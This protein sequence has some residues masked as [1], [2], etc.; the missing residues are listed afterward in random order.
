MKFHTRLTD[1]LVILLLVSLVIG[2]LLLTPPPPLASA[3]V[4]SPTATPPESPAPVDTPPVNMT[5]VPSPSL[6]PTETPTSTPLPPADTS[7]PLPAPTETLTPEPVSTNTSTPTSTSTVLPTG[8]ATATVTLETTTLTTTLEAATVAPTETATLTATPTPDLSSL[9]SSSITALAMPE[10]VVINEVAWSGTAASANHEWLELYN[11]TALTVALTGWVITNT[12][13]I[14]IPLSGTIDPH[15][16]YLIER[17]DD[18]ITDVIADITADLTA[19]FVLPNAGSGVNLFLSVGGV[20][21]DTANANADAWPAGMATPRVS[22]ER[23]DPLSPD[24]ASNWANN[25]SSLAWNGHAVNGTPINGTPKQPNSTTYTLPPVFP[26]LIGE[27]LYDGLT[28]STEGDEFVELCNPVTT[29]VSLA[30]YKI[31]DEETRGGGESM[32]QLPNTATIEANSCRVVAKN[33][34]QFQARFG[35]LPD[36]E[37]IVTG[38][39]YTDDPAVPNLSKYTTWGSGSWSLANDGD[40]LVVL[41]PADEIL[42]NVAYRNGNYASLEPEWE[43]SAPA[44]YSLQRVWPTDTNS[45]PHDFVR[46]DPNPGRLT[47]PPPPPAMPSVPAALPGGMY[48]FWGDLQAHTTYSDGAGPP[49]Y[50]LAMARAAGLHFYAI[51]D[52]D[53]RL[54]NL[55]WANTLIQTRQASVPGAFVALRGLEWTLDGAGHINVFNDDTLLNSHTDPLVD[56]LPEFYAWLAAHP[57]AIAQFNHPADDDGGDFD[58]FAYQP[59]AAPM[60]FMQEIGN[61]AQGYQTYEPA[62]VRS[63]TVGWK[64]AP[65]NNSDI[66]TA[67]WGS[68]SSA[69][70]G[71]VAPALTEPDLLEAIRARRVFAT[72][73]SNLAVALRI[74]GVWMGSSLSATGSLLLT[75]DMVDPDPEPLALFLYDG[76]LPLA[77]VSLATSTGQWTSMVNILPGHFFWVKVVQADGNTAYTAPVWIEG[78]ALPDTLYV[79]EILPAPHDWDWDGN[80]TPD[81]QDEWIELY[82]PTNRPIG[83]GGWQLVDSSGFTYDIPLG[84]VIQPD[85]YAVFFYTQTGISLNNGSDAVR[86]IHPGGVMV[87]SFSYDHSPGYDESWCRLPDGG[88]G[89][90]DNCGPSPM[91]ANWEKAA[92]GPLAVKIFE[93][94]RLSDDAWVRVKGRVTAPPGVLGS[95]NM[96]IQDDT[97]GILIYLP[98][99]HNLYFNLGDKVTVVGNV[100]TFHEEFEIVVDERSDVKFLEPGLP[101][102]P[103]PIVTTSLLEPYEGMLV[104]LQGYTVRFKGRT[105]FWLDDGT[106]PA[107]V[108]LRQSTGI[109]KPYIDRDTPVTVV[110]IV[111]QYSEE[112]DPSRNDY[113]LLPRYQ[114]DLIIAAPATI[115]T[116]WPSLLPETGY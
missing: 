116:H 36:F 57:T 41:G 16:Y 98:K 54:A 61:R 63:N 59:A 82:N 35:F 109:K 94:K 48:V 25:D 110:G 38:S 5:T 51:T 24:T 81:Y 23:V 103:L 33:A 112:D 107:K 96:Y 60:M 101:L 14:S 105:T 88:A 99:D 53:W 86:L 22:M 111:S 1:V 26:I 84:L 49:Y 78:E 108:Y 72:E 87:D 34:A 27:F 74:N 75:V 113:R 90:S 66:H 39:S 65:T 77:T 43:A 102:P 10:D 70:T 80:G 76:N 29:T 52:H 32:Y 104:M 15:S 69:R 85:A 95:R 93:A 46:T 56:T 42:D 20:V 73:D 12:G 13:S 37:V 89:W 4:D 83:L 21:I 58:N 40:E 68:D 71:I 19:N 114:T 55:E 17:G 64:V 45:M 31:G 2:L 6:T 30:N 79:N 67:H 106:D 8:T 97:A 62:F 47:L 9:V 3:Q 50:A 100:R 11:T 28:S 18:T 44:P 92:N 7:T 91:A 115:P